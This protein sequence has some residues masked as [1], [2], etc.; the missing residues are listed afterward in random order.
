MSKPR[1]QIPHS[2]YGPFCTAIVVVVVKHEGAA[3]RYQERKT[4]KKSCACENN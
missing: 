3:R 4:M 2:T 1:S